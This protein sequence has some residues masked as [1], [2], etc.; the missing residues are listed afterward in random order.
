VFDAPSCPVGGDDDA[1]PGGGQLGAAPRVGNRGGDQLGEV[2]HA[3]LGVRRQRRT[4]G[5]HPHHAPQAALDQDRAGSRRADPHP[6]VRVD[7]CS[8]SGAPHRRHGRQVVGLP[9]RP[10]RCLPVR[11]QPGDHGRGTVRLE[12]GQGGIVGAKQPAG[13]LGGRGEYLGRWHPMRGQ[14][15]DTAER[16]LLLQTPTELDVL[17][18]GAV[19]GPLGD[20]ARGHHVAT[21]PW[22]SLIHGMLRRWWG[23]VEQDDAVGGGQEGRL[24]GAVGDPVEVPL[25]PADVVAPV[26]EGWPERRLGD[27]RVV[28]QRWDTGSARAGDGASCRSRRAHRVLLVWASRGTGSI[29]TGGAIV[30]ATGRGSNPGIP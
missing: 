7:P 28:G 2:R 10:G 29:P 24:V 8:A 23:G 30:A 17:L 19:D 20:P 22:T 15:G 1:G 6:A 9:A 25:H 16:G 13:L 4:L 27:W 12:A 3:F 18:A 5:R 14:H 26:V 21:S 11:A